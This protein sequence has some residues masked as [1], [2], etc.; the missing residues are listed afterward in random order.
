MMTR[1]H[2]FIPWLAAL[3]L[4]GCAA[5]PKY[6]RPPAPVPGEWPGGSASAG[7]VTPAEAPTALELSWPEFLNDEK[8]VQ[9]VEMALKNNRDLRIAA[10][11]VERAR[12]LYGI[13]YADLLPVVEASGRWSEQEMHLSFLDQTM[14]VT[15]ASVDLGI[16]SW[17][18][19]L[20]GRIRSLKDKA[21]EEFLATAQAHR[22]ARILLVAETANAYYTLA[23]D[24][25]RLRIA[26]STLDTQRA[27]YELIQ[28]RFAGGI[29]PELDLKQAQTRVDAAQVDIAVYTRLA[30]LDEN[31]LNLLAGQPVPAGLLPDGLQ[32][33]QPPRDISPGVSS[34]VLL[35]RPDILQAEH[36]LKAANANIN[37]ARAAFFPRIS[38]TT[39]LGTAS[40]QLSGLFAS[41]SSTWNYAPQIVMPIFD[42]RVWFGFKAT[43]IEREIALAHYEK[44]IQ[45]AFREVADALAVRGTIGE[46]LAAQQSLLDAVAETYRLSELRY[47]K[48]VENYLTVLDAQRS[49]YDAQQGLVAA[50]LMELTNR[51]RLFAVLGGGFP[52]PEA[53]PAGDRRPEVAGGEPSHGHLANVS[54]PSGDL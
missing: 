50:R 20:F 40:G 45:S 38:L 19:D 10:L 29:S 44:A 3:L 46:Q 9:V 37:A 26:Q 27:A 30:A 41:G 52:A 17:E 11:N 49:L 51:V 6:T 47:T 21:L 18:I 28:K 42:T 31:A 25:E 15:S 48:G 24:R 35:A 23:A 2:R 16:T 4:Q 13:R 22:G 12:N 54:Q 53:E 36:Q 33:I 14:K 5:N 39:A 7:S 8:L 43:Q 1:T 34:D 32:A